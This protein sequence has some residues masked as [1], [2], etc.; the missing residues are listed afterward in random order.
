MKKDPIIL[1]IESSCDDT[2]VALMQGNLVLSHVIGTQK[3]HSSYG[4]VVP[5]LASR[6]H[7][8]DIVPLVRRAGALANINQK[9]LNAVAF[10]KGPGLIGSLLVGANFAKSLAMAL[11]IPCIGVHHVQAH[12]LAHFIKIQGRLPPEFPFLCLT[13]S[14]G[15]TQIVYVEDYFQMTVLGQ[16]LDDA[17][18]EAFDKSAKIMGLEYPGGVWVDRYAQ[19]GDPLKF[20]FSKPRVK[21]LDFSFSGFKT[22]FLYFIQKQ[23]AIDS[24][25]IKKNLYDLCASVQHT[26]VNILL[27]K[28]LQ[29]MAQTN[30]SQLALAGGVSANSGL[31]QRFLRASE[32]KG[33]RLYILPL[34]Y[35]TDNAAMIAMT[36]QLK[37]ARSLFDNLDIVATSCCEWDS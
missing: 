25:F 6:F 5:E 11:E 16:N 37:Y 15:H 9:Q 20:P 33:W 8:K 14:G 7:Q 10:T 22:Q 30:I 26:L 36:A 4:G 2:A 18:G 29:A 35:T 31:R 21:G 19:K 32:E 27:D 23:L 34:E 12:V 1:A 17:V 28:V 24:D 3:I 13:I